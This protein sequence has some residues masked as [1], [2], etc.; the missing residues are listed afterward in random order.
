M[1]LSR[2]DGAQVSADDFILRV[3]IPK[4][5][6]QIPV[7]VQTSSTRSGPSLP[8]MGMDD[9]GFLRSIKSAVYIKSRPSFCIW[10]FGA[11]YSPVFNYFDTFG[12]AIGDSRECSKRPR[13]RK[14]R[15]WMFLTRGTGLRHKRQLLPQCAMAYCRFLG[16]AFRPLFVLIGGSIR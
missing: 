9:R 8:S 13:L 5:M 3:L 14:N 11:Q 1:G 10:S 6:A 2:L 15:C 4:S 16:L 7:P 12:R